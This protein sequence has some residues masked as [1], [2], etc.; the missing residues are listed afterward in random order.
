MDNQKLINEYNDQ[1]TKGTSIKNTDVSLVEGLFN[2]NYLK[3][4]ATTNITNKTDIYLD[5]DAQ[6]NTV[7]LVT[8]EDAH[9][10]GFGEKSS[11]ALG[12]MG[13]AAFNVN[14]WVNSSNID[15]AK[16]QIQN[17][18]KVEV[19]GVNDAQAQ[20]DLLKANTEK[21]ESQIA[22]NDEFDEHLTNKRFADLQKYLEF[23]KSSPNANGCSQVDKN[24]LVAKIK[25]I[26][27]DNLSV[28]K[29]CKA[30][31]ESA[32]MEKNVQQIWA[33]EQ[34]DDNKLKQLL[35][36]TNVG[37]ASNYDVKAADPQLFKQLEFLQYAQK[38]CQGMSYGDCGTKYTVSHRSAA[39]NI[40][41]PAKSKVLDYIVGE[42]PK[43]GASYYLAGIG[44]VATEILFP[45]SGTDVALM[46]IGGA[47]GK[48]GK[49]A[50][51]ELKAESGL[52]NAV[53]GS[54]VKLTN[55][56]PEGLAICL[57]G[58]CFTAGT[59]IETDQGFKAVENFVG[60]ERVWS[61]NDRTLEYG[62]RPVIATK[63]TTD[64]VIFEVVI[65]NQQ[66]QQEKLETTAE[67]PFWVKN[68]GWLKSSLLQSG[69]TLL[70]RNN[71]ELTVVNQVLIPNKV[72]TVYNIEVDGFHTYHVGELGTWVHNANC[73]DIK[74]TNAF[75]PVKPKL[76][77]AVDI[78][79]KGHGL[80]N[81]DI[82]TKQRFDEKGIPAD[83][84]TT[85][86]FLY[87]S[88]DSK[89]GEF[90]IQKMEAYQ[91]G[92][93]TGKEM[94]SQ[95]IEKIGYSKI[96]SAKAE[97]ADTN[98]LAFENA[99]TKSGNTIEAVNNTPLGK[100]MN[101]LGFK[102]DSIDRNLGGM[103]KVKFIRK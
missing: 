77:Y 31:G 75:V 40:L 100:A 43:S 38:N 78:E 11:E 76:N 19:K 47:A 93:N 7:N 92:N 73:C 59:L 68:F 23:C 3:A 29:S 39:E 82:S 96:N 70:D 9:Q 28:Y 12:W 65:Q 85:K 48:G 49:L 67:H 44:Y 36:S 27:A 95:A 60:G 86:S 103:P 52:A 24:K 83:T 35:G 102:V 25:Q 6:K 4:D 55:Q 26:S 64:Q 53:E 90:Y 16:T 18:P 94:L 33:A 101:D 89:S 30:S 45:E 81:I 88:F 87:S 62:Y 51:T 22:N 5:K 63:E 10:V 80:Q 20:L 32:C 1:L 37:L 34:F 71:E 91:K 98:K 56:A 14:S 66:G 97:L 72:E 15:T 42:K 21:Y 99:Y 84:R 61:R 13:E 69:M 46:A 57:N 2:E 54:Y 41:I 58:V 8:H 17:I 74:S 50:G 79:N